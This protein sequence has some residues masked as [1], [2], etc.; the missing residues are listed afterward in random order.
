MTW[1]QAFL[2]ALMSVGILCCVVTVCAGVL[3]GLLHLM[4]VYGAWVFF[5]FVG[6]LIIGA[7]T[8]LN[9]LV[10]GK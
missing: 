4:Q 8:G 2:R 3:V 6:V 9:K 5:V 1:S 10:G 7:A